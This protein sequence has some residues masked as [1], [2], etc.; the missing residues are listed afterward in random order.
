MKKHKIVTNNKEIYEKFN[1]LN[2][3]SEVLIDNVET[4]QINKIIQNINRDGLN[5][6]CE[7]VG[8]Y[9]IVRK[10]QPINFNLY[11]LSNGKK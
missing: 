10:L 5:I 8:A 9:F 11:M 1:L 3:S 2:F 6:Q 7:K 4:K